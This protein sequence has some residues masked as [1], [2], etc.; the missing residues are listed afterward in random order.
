MINEDFKFDFSSGRFSLLFDE[1]FVVFEIE[2]F[3]A[4]EEHD[5]ICQEVACISQESFESHDAGGKQFVRTSDPRFLRLIT[6]L[7]LEG[8]RKLVNRFRSL[9]CCYA[10]KRFYG[11]HLGPYGARTWIVKPGWMPFG[12]Y[13]V[14]ARWLRYIG[15]EFLRF[16]ME[17]SV[18]KHNDSIPP[19]TDLPEKLVSLVYYLQPEDDDHPR[20]NW[21]T[22][23]FSGKTGQTWPEF[24]S[25]ML[26]DES[27]DKF[28]DQHETWYVSAFVG[29]KLV[30]FIKDAVSWHAVNPKKRNINGSR[31]ALVFNVFCVSR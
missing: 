8:L 5:R 30:G 10:L 25:R 27:T 2:N 9:Q 17:L 26:G 6:L 18:L 31:Y 1:P 13:R 7:E 23:F 16:E 3:L 28:L 11:A 21:G 22:E 29:N 19:H 24:D 15:V 14:L 4:K 12:M 20:K